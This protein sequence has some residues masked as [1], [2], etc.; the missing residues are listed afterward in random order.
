[1]LPKKALQHDVVCIS[2]DY[3]QLIPFLIDVAQDKLQ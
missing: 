1:M 2:R 3:K